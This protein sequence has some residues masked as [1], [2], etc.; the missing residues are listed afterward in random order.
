MKLGDLRAALQRFT[1]R[2]P[3]IPLALVTVTLIALVV[4]PLTAEWY[5]RPLFEELRTVTAPAQQLLTRVHIALALEGATLRDFAETRSPALAMRYQSVVRS[6]D[7]AQRQL[8][9]LMESLGPYVREQFVAL[10]RAERE[11][12]AAARELLEGRPGGARSESR[13]DQLYENVLISAARLDQALDEAVQQRRSRIREAGRLQRA[14]SVGL[15][16]LALLALGAVGW[17][18]R[19]LRTAAAEAEEGRRAVERLMDSKTRLMRGVTHDIKNP[20]NAINGYASLLADGIGGPVTRTQQEQIERIRKSARSVLALLDDLLE[21]ARA[22]V[23][24]LRIVCRPTDVRALVLDAVDQHRPQVEAAAHTFVT[25]VPN[26]FPL[27]ATDPARVRQV[28]GNLISNGS[29]YTPAGGR[30]SVELE[31]LDAVARGP[32]E[33]LVAVHVTDTGPGIPPS[34]LERVFEEF[35]RLDQSGQGGSGLGLAIARRIARLL[36][37]DITV[38]SELGSGSRFTLWLPAD[39]SGGDG[40]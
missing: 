26:D 37:G 34:Q 32:R 36:G 2:S 12:H 39:C 22:D 5:T 38:Q 21:L 30:I 23:G 25:H 18:A 17:L 7:D 6:K 29:K 20:L 14:V 13:R 19:R 35:T 33:A 11:W 8:H 40:P 4:A 15:S 1:P 28:L 24:R 27:I 16:A 3:V 31:L 10:Q 9:A